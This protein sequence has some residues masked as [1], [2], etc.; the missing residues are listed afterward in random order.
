[1]FA[2]RFLRTAGARAFSSAPKPTSINGKGSLDAIY[3]AFMKNNITYVST[4]VV[5]AVLFEGVYGTTTSALWESMNRGRLYHHIDWS[6]FKSDLDDEEEA[7]DE[8]DE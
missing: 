6:Q 7:E 1:M 2:Q 3:A 4:I 8:D 5:A